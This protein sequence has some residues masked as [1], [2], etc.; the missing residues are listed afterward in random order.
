M[1]T[2]LFTASLLI[3]MACGESERTGARVSRCIPKSWIDAIEAED[4]MRDTVLY[5][6]ECDVEETEREWVFKIKGE[7]TK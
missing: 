2:C 7:K 5:G 4:L 6:F 3:G 1:T